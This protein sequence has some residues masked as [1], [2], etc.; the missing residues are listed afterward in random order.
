MAPWTAP[1]LLHPVGLDGTVD[2]WLCC[3]LF[4]FES[5]CQCHSVTMEFTGILQLLNWLIPSNQQFQTI[6]RG[7]SGRHQAAHMHLILPLYRGRT[8]SKKRKS[9]SSGGQF[10]Q[11]WC[12]AMK[13]KMGAH[14]RS[15]Y[16]SFGCME[17]NALSIQ[18][19]KDDHIGSL[20]KELC[21]YSMQIWDNET[22]R[23]HWQSQGDYSI[24][25]DNTHTLK[26]PPNP[27]DTTHT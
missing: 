7:A 3:M 21:P 9:A 16:R 1:S 12:W 4:V 26:T 17:I 23:N 10:G 20:L 5:Q 18:L 8:E 24:D 22:K 2:C 19:E 13:T 15:H 25:Q 14:M 27:L 6:D 11:G